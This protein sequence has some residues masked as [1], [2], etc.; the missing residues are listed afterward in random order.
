MRNQVLLTESESKDL[1]RLVEE[2][3]TS[4]GMSTEELIIRLDAVT[5]EEFQTGLKEKIQNYSI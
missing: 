1:E 2:F 5:F 4:D 3:N